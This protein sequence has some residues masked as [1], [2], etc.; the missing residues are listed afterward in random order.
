MHLRSRTFWRRIGLIL[1]ALAWLVVQF[2]MA[3]GVQ[4]ASSSG[5]AVEICSGLSVET[6]LVDPETG[7]PVDP[8]TAQDEGCD[9]CRSFGNAV[10]APPRLG[11][12][13]RQ[14]AFTA[15][16]RIL[17][18]ETPRHPLRLVGEIRSRAPPIL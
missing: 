8:E 11:L 10:V 4:A 1:P 12:D 14:V 17:P 2:A 7:L 15:S 13:W 3:G 16:R 9:W 18:A 5:V 6:I